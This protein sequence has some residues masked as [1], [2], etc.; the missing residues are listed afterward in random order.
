MVR[1]LRA[2]TEPISTTIARIPAAVSA[3]RRPR[4]RPMPEP[5]R[6]ATRTVRPRAATHSGTTPGNVERPALGRLGDLGDD[7]R[8]RIAGTT[9][10][11]WPDAEAGNDPGGV[12]ESERE[13]ATRGVAEQA[14]HVALARAEEL[15]PQRWRPQ[16]ADD[17]RADADRAP[18]LGRVDLVA[19]PDP[20]TDDAEHEE[21]EDV[22]VGDVRL[23]Q[24]RRDHRR[25]REQSVVAGGDPHADDQQRDEREDRAR[26]PA[27]C[28]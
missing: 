3:R 26:W 24:Q 18:P 27:R 19:L 2:S 9:P 28:R 1:R 23:Q 14:G 10:E 5:A 15:L 21:H 11:R 16:H 7:D 8:R 17:R 4:A 22:G 13:V 6:I 25:P 20:D 12:V